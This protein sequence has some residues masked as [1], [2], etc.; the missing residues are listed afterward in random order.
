VCN[1][2][3]GAVD[4]IVVNVVVS[5]RTEG[6]GEEKAEVVAVVFDGAGL[7]LSDGAWVGE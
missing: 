2:E 6:V 7:D 5:E 3:P 1:S 4:W